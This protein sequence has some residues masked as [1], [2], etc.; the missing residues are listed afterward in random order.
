VC[1]SAQR[2][3]L[4]I[5]HRMLPGR[6]Y[7]RGLHRHHTL[8][9]AAATTLHA[10]R[11]CLYAGECVLRGNLSQ[12]PGCVLSRTGLRLHWGRSVLCPLLVHRG[13]LCWRLGIW[14]SRVESSRAGHSTGPR[15]RNVS[16]CGAPWT[17]QASRSVRSLP[18]M[19][20]IDVTRVG[21]ARVP[22][23]PTCRTSARALQR[24]VVLECS[25]SGTDRH[26][27]PPL[28]G[29]STRACAGR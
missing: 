27:D 10:A 2:P 9:T 23:H 22:G 12:R 20:A 17:C 13:L 28:V 21:A 29:R 8:A 24:T 6:V 15:I 26:P 5:H 3:A 14:A 16:S 19:E 1:L 25:R 18:L 7:Q 11:R 4:R